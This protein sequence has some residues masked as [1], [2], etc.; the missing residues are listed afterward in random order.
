MAIYVQAPHKPTSRPIYILCLISS[1]IVNGEIIY[2]RL[3]KWLG[4][5]VILNNINGGFAIGY[6][7]GKTYAKKIF[8]N[9][10]NNQKSLLILEGFVGKCRTHVMDV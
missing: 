2:T 3:V 9:N 6:F 5:G 10:Y 1:D 7:T 4:V 8:D